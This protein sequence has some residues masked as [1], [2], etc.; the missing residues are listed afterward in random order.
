[1]HQAP[2]KILTAKYQAVLEREQISKNSLEEGFVQ[3]KPF[4]QQTGLLSESLK[5]HS[6]E[7][8]FE[9]FRV[10]RTLWLMFRGYWQ[11]SEKYLIIEKMPDS[12]NNSSQCCPYT[13]T[14]SSQFT[15]YL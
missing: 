4:S 12:R 13:L 7:G 1:M 8:E 6:S 9:F 10:F 11:L 2:V 14:T 5:N 15:K 3:L